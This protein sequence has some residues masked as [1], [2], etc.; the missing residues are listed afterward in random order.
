[1]VV[2][3]VDVFS[4]LW[5]HLKMDG[6]DTVKDVKGLLE[7]VTG[8]PC[9]DITLK[10]GLPSYA[11]CPDDCQ[12]KDLNDSVE[13]KLMMTNATAT[14]LQKMHELKA[15]QKTIV[16]DNEIKIHGDLQIAKPF[17]SLWSQHLP[18]VD[19]A[20]QTAPHQASH[21][22]SSSAS[23]GVSTMTELKDEIARLEKQILTNKARIKELKQ[24]CREEPITIQLRQPSGNLS[25][26]ITYTG[27][28]VSQCKR[29]DIAPV[30]GIPAGDIKLMMG[31]ELLADKRRLFSYNI[32]K[33]TVVGLVKMNRAIVADDTS[34]DESI[35][36]T[37]KPLNPKFDMTIVMNEY[38]PDIH[39]GKAIITMTSETTGTMTYIFHFTR[40]DKFEELY[41]AL[42]EYHVAVTDNGDMTMRNKHNM[43]S[44]TVSYETISSWVTSDSKDLELVIVAS[45]FLGSGKRAVSGKA[46]AGKADKETKMKDLTEKVGT[47]L[48]RIGAGNPPDFIQQI[49][50][51]IVMLKDQLATKPDLIMDGL[52][53]LNVEEVKKLQS[54][55]GSSH[56]YQRVI[57]VTKALY[58]NEH[59]QV[60]EI[61]KLCNYLTDA[62][63]GF[64]E[65][66]IMTHYSN[67]DGSLQWQKMSS[68]LIEI[69]SKNGGSDST[70]PMPNARGLG[71]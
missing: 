58:P 6:L 61:A 55:L 11:N 54:G 33:G 24:Q 71:Y 31:M 16:K 65:L 28:T 37:T 10:N 7:E 35:H 23:G 22:P 57:A 27:R 25:N 59:V 32:D 66:C 18:V 44:R 26:I 49:I 53:T 34:S 69:A 4:I 42:L 14:H 43:M 56:T 52:S 8:I 17:I 1:M 50:N 68:D 36:D 13:F 5:V 63:N 2:V 62:M 67:D 46:K 40:H 12:L 41:T 39:I 47:T 29:L 70:T 19:D 64:V 60:E 51:N 15:L 38:E 3:K 30:L 9:S 48:L 20:S 21:L 45:G